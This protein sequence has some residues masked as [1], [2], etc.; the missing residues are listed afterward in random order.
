MFTLDEINVELEK[1]NEF[2]GLKMIPQ[3]HKIEYKDDLKSLGFV[4]DKDLVFNKYIIYLSSKTTNLPLM[5][6]KAICWHE[7][8]HIADY[9]FYKDKYDI[10]SLL[11][12]Y[13]EAHATFIEMHYLTNTPLSQKIKNVNMKIEYSN[14][15]TKVLDVNANHADQFYKGMAMFLETKDPENFDYAMN[16]FL[17][18]C[19]CLMLESKGKDIFKK[20]MQSYELPYFKSDLI[21]LGESIFKKNIQLCIKTYNSIFVQAVELTIQ[22]II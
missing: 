14:E 6:Q 19:G 9:L 2:V 11:K 18:F 1:Y 17:Y 8:T 21:I 20:L 22:P 10:K 4:D 13:S 15:L 12:S 7:L 5:R 16:H 3:I